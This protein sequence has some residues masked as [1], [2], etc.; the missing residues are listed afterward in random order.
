MLSFMDKYIMQNNPKMRKAMVLF[1]AGYGVRK[2]MFI[3]F[4][5]QVSLMANR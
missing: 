2:N 3:N 5:N 4:V 1:P